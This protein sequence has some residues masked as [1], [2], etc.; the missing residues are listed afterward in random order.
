M[1]ADYKARV[2]TEDQKA[3]F[4]KLAS[5]IRGSRQMHRNGRVIKYLRKIENIE[6]F[7]NSLVYASDGEQERQKIVQKESEQ[8]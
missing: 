5:D 6:D 2:G 1:L 4:D 8:E 3:A 7:F